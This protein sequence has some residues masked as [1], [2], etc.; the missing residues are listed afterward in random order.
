[1]AESIIIDLQN[2]GTLG[3]IRVAGYLNQTGGEELYQACMRLLA[4]G[5]QDLLINLAQC[6]KVNSG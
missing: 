3:I 5:V 6:T 1:M 2:D 4:D